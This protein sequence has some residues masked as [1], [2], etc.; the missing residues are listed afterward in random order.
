MNVVSVVNLGHYIYYS[1]YPFFSSNNMV[2]CSTYHLPSSSPSSDVLHQLLSKERPFE[3]SRYNEPFTEESSP[4]DDDYVFND[5]KS[6][7]TKYEKLRQ[8][9]PQFE[10]LKRVK[11]F[12]KTFL[13]EEAK[14]RKSEIVIPLALVWV[15]E[16]KAEIA[17]L[18]HRSF[19]NKLWLHRIELIR[20]KDNEK[21]SSLQKFENA[22]HNAQEAIK[23]YREFIYKEYYNREELQEMRPLYL[24]RLEKAF[25]KVI[26]EKDEAGFEMIEEDVVRFGCPTARLCALLGLKLDFL[27]RLEKIPPDHYHHRTLRDWIEIILQNNVE[28]VASAKKTSL[29]KELLGSI[30]FDP[31]STAVET[32]MARS[33]EGSAQHHI[34]ASEWAEIFI[35]DEFKYNPLISSP[36][37]KFPFQ[38]NLTNSWFQLPSLTSEESEN[39][40]DI[41]HV[42]FMNLVTKA[43]DA[44][45]D[46]QSILS[47]FVSQNE[48]NI[49]LF[50]GTDHA[51]AVDILSRGIDLCASRKK[52]DFSCG[53]GFYLTKSLD[54]ALNWAHST[55]AKPAILVFQVRRQYFDDARKLNLSNDEERWREIVSSFRSA[56]R[57]GKTRKQL[58]SFDLIEGPMATV[59]RSEVSDDPVLEPKP[60][61]YQMCLISDDFAEEFRKTLYSIVFLDIS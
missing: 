21:Y 30:G 56:K 19:L 33:S 53:S 5:F 26:E 38:G 39:T 16:N 2:S 32:I 14:L 51:S 1:F 59:R 45:R 4:L 40:E 35:K 17:R 23:G 7:A 57:T 28:S 41:C 3:F 54:H 27:D 8:L 18:E 44:C 31:L 36:F 12:M 22:I 47:D 46:T 24:E 42:L 43:P 11:S 9:L 49:V 10:A 58:N 48:E 55:T 60:S 6:L 37:V 15:D 50:H 61:S 34:E 25:S 13:Q 52:R 29:T 20:D